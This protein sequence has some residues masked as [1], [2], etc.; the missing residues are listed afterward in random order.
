[1]I[2][3]ALDAMGGDYAPTE[4]VKGAVLASQE[5]PIQII[6]V[7]DQARLENEL[8]KYPKRGL[9]TI[10]PAT[11]VI[12]NNESPVAAVKQKKD[13]SLN[14]AVS[15]VKKKEAEAVVSAG[16]TGALMAASLFGLGRISGVERPAIATIFPTPS[17]PILLLDM[18]AN[19]DCKPKNL[20]QFA[21]MGSQ[22]AEHV[23]HISK[24]RVGLLN[25]GEEKEKGNELVIQTWPLLYEDKK[26]NFI[27]NVESK[28]VLNGRVDVVVCDGFVGNLVLKFGESI[29]DFVVTLL[30]KE[31]GKN[32]ITKF[33]AF[34]LLPALAS[35]KKSVDY[36]EAGGAPMLGIDGIVFKAHGRAKAK[37]IKNA[38]RV[39]YEAIKEDLIGCISKI[40]GSS[41]S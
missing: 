33:A 23:M 40:E 22:Y 27:G 13:S 30:K 36:D 5:Y 25:I 8:K 10:A 32:L 35:I 39:T 11:E 28:E 41:E 12:G 38:I 21:E 4:I 18:G 7:G 31:M 14:V 17:G 26:I 34:L 2:K 20:Q 37:A 15:L 19:V 29:T 1:V 24:P 9:I 3:V 16:N 6:L